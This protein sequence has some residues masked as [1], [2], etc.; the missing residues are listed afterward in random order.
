MGIERFT[1]ITDVL[2]MG[3]IMY[4]VFGFELTKKK[5]NY[6]FVILF[7]IISMEGM[8]YISTDIAYEAFFVLLIL[9][10]VFQGNIF[11]K[12]R[13]LFL[14]YIFIGL[15]DAFIRFIIYRFTNWGITDSRM[16]ILSQLIGIV[17]WSIV[18]GV[19]YKKRK[20]L[21][22][23]FNAM[24]SVVFVLS[25]ISLI[26]IS[27][28]IGGVQMLIYGEATEKLYNF[29]FMLCI[30]IAF[31]IVMLCLLL[32]NMNY[33][34]KRL[35]E[36]NRLNQENMKLQQKYIQD[37]YKKNEDLRA[38]RHDYNF[39]MDTLKLLLASNNREG[40]ESYI[41]Q[42]SEK[43]ECTRYIRTGNLLA[44]AVMNNI[45]AD[46]KEEDQIQFEITG[47]FPEKINMEETDLCGLLANALTNAKEAVLKVDSEKIIMV[48]I[49]QYKDK[50]YLKIINRSN[51][52]GNENQLITDKREQLNHGYGIKNMKAIV[53]KYKG[54]FYWKYED[55]F[56]ELEVNI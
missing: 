56:F 47:K 40:L 11:K 44:D 50:L 38:F 26:S 51:P 16:L 2:K 25:F 28:L 13:M 39:H 23:Y 37:I 30:M 31:F 4:G 53:E 21:K 5:R 17:F 10:F 27:L 32:V 15:I 14:D 33:S 29:G 46:I 55:G 20:N 1:F 8:P 34:K 35:E 41:N 48:D 54:E 12:I 43:K 24:T 19:L 7:S 9:F 52:V 49:K 36:V 3:L 6:V 22:N 18:L 42:L 45:L